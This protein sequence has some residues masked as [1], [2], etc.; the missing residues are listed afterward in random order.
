MN[1]VQDAKDNLATQKQL[2]IKYRKLLFVQECIIS[3]IM[4]EIREHCPHTNIKKTDE[5]DYHH[6]TDW[7]ESNCLDCGKYLGRV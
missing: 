2:L 4:V 5:Y 6:G 1:K 7:V 3:S